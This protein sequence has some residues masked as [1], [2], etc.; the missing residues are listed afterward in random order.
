M[1]VNQLGRYHYLT[2]F[3]DKLFGNSDE[4]GITCISSGKSSYI[5][6]QFMLPLEKNL[7]IVSEES[8]GILK[9]EEGNMKWNIWKNNHLQ[10]GYS[11]LT[12]TETETGVVLGG[13][14]GNMFVFCGETL[15]RID[16]S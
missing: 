13:E 14:C 8:F 7:L 15:K 11:M 10:K 9:M 6:C 3:N 2:I 16:N 4:K 1:A 12:G 5:P